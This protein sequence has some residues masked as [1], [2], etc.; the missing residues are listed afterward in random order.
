VS[1][2]WTTKNNTEYPTILVD[3]YIVLTELVKNS[4]TLISIDQAKQQVTYP[5]FPF[6]TV[7]GIEEGKSYPVLLNGVGE[8]IDDPVLSTRKIYVFVEKS[9][10]GSLSYDGSIYKSLKK[11]I[12]FPSVSGVAGASVT[13]SY[14]GEEVP[15]GLGTIYFYMASGVQDPLYAGGYGDLTQ[16]TQRTVSLLSG[17]SN[18]VAF[19][20]SPYYLDAPTGGSI[21]GGTG[22]GVTNPTT[23]PPSETVAVPH[24]YL[25]TIQGEDV[26]FHIALFKSEVSS[27]R[28]VMNDG[29][30]VAVGLVQVTDPDASPI[31][32]MTENGIYAMKKIDIV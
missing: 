5:L 32:V 31:R 28:V 30:F 16:A 18:N 29:K 13:H 20:Y 1:T 27:I 21:G 2:L 7:W 24:D 11:T 6:G 14:G 9:L 22:G 15:D 8:F 4:N 23:P 26:P 19:Y 10:D 3:S 25:M 17:R 12:S